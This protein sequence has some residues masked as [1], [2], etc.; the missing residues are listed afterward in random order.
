[1]GQRWSHEDLVNNFYFHNMT[2][3]WL[4]GIV[5][6]LGFAI[7]P[8]FVVAQT[9]P[10]KID[11]TEYEKAG[12]CLVEAQTWYN[13]E[14][15]KCL[16]EKSEPLKKYQD[17]TRYQKGGAEKIQA[18]LPQVQAAQ[19][20]CY[21]GPKLEEF[22]KRMRVCYEQTS[23][24]G[25]WDLP[26]VK[27][28][29]VNAMDDWRNLSPQE[30]ENLSKCL[31]DLSV[32]NDLSQVTAH[33]Q[34]EIA[35]CFTEVG[36]TSFAKVYKTTSVVLDCA[37]ARF[38]IQTREDVVRVFANQTTE[39][40]EYIEQCVLKKVAPVITVTSAASLPLVA[41]WK[42]IF[43]FGQLLVTQP[44]VL[45]RKRKYKTWGTVFDATTLAPVDLSSVRLVETAN[46][47][48]VS[49]TVTNLTGSYLFLAKPGKYRV[50]VNKQGYN[51]PSALL[52]A[53]AFE[54]DHYFGEPIL[55]HGEHDVIDRHVPIDPETKPISIFQFRLRQSRYQLATVLG[56]VSPTISFIGFILIPKW[57]VGLLALTHILIFIIFLRLS[58]RNKIKKFG[59]VTDKNKKTIS[60]VQVSLFRKQ[61]NKLLGFYVTDLFGRYYFPRL[62]GE[63]FLVFKKSGFVE[64]KVSL[65]L[66]KVTNKNT[67]SHDVQLK[68]LK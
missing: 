65:A 17:P 2:A 59:V 25:V 14:V 44:I 29:L 30:G 26:A 41:G 43:L 40:R 32:N 67:I 24:G 8:S 63:Y 21:Q 18:L 36:L 13:S 60:G 55:V 45:L 33:N 7:T 19:Q 51:F 28:T 5:L 42:S 12:K 49:T 6:S 66:S 27:A 3:R 52:A 20:T 57:W 50:E 39:D 54:R 15:S 38:P 64:E 9:N 4:A 56:L 22:K 23:F 53:G 68:S 62:V 37:Q 31:T 46:N 16:T 10:S 11:G 47:K 1:M 48:I 58:G 35:A 61:D 34:E